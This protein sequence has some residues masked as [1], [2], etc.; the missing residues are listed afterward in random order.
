M[1]FRVVQTHVRGVPL[2][3]RDLLRMPGTLGELLTS[4]TTDPRYKGIV[5]VAKLH[6]R[7]GGPGS[8]E[9]LPALYDVTLRVLATQ[10][11]LLTGFERVSEPGRLT[12]EY[13]QGW[14]AR[15]PAVKE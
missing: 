3:R 13:V 9:L 7:G 4:E 12:V 10:G 14:W 15:L 6:A 2:S 1:R 5:C 11:I 8:I